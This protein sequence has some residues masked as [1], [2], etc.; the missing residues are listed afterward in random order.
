MSGFAGVGKGGGRSLCSLKNGVANIFGTSEID[1]Q[2]FANSIR[3]LAPGFLI[4][5]FRTRYVS[6]RMKSLSS[7]L[8]EYLL[9]S[10]IYYVVTFSIFDIARAY[11]KVNFTLDDPFVALIWTF[12]LPVG[13]GVFLGAAVQKGWFRFI[14]NWLRLNAIT[15]HM[16][17][18]DGAFSTLKNHA[19][20]SVHTKS[21]GIVCGKFTD[22]SNAS[23][24]LSRSDIFLEYVFGD[25]FPETEDL[26][27]DHKTSMWISADEI[28]A[29]EFHGGH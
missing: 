10:S 1:L 15:P 7:A 21:M 29:I 19:W 24:D 9:F 12:L 16:T 6:G 4:I 11:E 18:W 2:D 22:R 23:I 25:C 26:D 27:E 5:F 8:L 17:G 13:V 28:I 14:E 20:V 3:L